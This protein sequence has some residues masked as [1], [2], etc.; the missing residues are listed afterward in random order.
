[1]NQIRS[2]SNQL[3]KFVIIFLL[4]ESFISGLI[5]SA[6][7]HTKP[8]NIIGRWNNKMPFT[9]NY[10]DITRPLSI[11]TYIMWPQHLQ[12]N[13]SNSW[14]SLEYMFPECLRKRAKDTIECG[15]RHCFHCALRQAPSVCIMTFHTRLE[16]VSICTIAV[17]S[18][19]ETHSASEHMLNT[20]TLSSPG[21]ELCSTSRWFKVKLTSAILDIKC[22][23]LILK[24]FVGKRERIKLWAKT[25]GEVTVIFDPPKTCLGLILRVH[26]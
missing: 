5:V 10:V 1:M 16:P 22:Y 23:C 14:W 2:W 9:R 11:R 12:L 6:G 4:A 20:V 21:P 15:S 18:S 26:T 3:S 17:V 8:Y 25:L 7:F 13:L 24:A 19:W